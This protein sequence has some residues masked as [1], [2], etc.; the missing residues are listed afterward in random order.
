MRE[1]LWPVGRKMA[2]GALSLAMVCSLMLAGGNALAQTNDAQ[3]QTA[4]DQALAAAVKGDYVSALNLA[5][6][7]ASLGH[8]MDPDIVDNFTTRAARQAALVADAARLKA[9]QE[10][11]APLADKIKDR[12]QKDYADRAKKAAER[13]TC[14]RQGQQMAGLAQG[15]GSVNQ[16]AGSISGGAGAAAASAPPSGVGG[17][18][19]GC[20]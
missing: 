18:N 9:A 19:A 8:P 15:I 20:G 10:A 6:K 4:S 5:Q 14:T 11:A 17:Y 3:A 7:A 2:G 16:P 1:K 13:A 12:Q